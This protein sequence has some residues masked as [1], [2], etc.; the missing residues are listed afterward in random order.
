MAKNY[1][2]GF[3][4]VGQCGHIAIYERDGERNSPIDCPFCEN[5]ALKLRVEALEKK[6]RIVR[7]FVTLV[8]DVEET[9]CD[10]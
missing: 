4:H 3:V 7:S 5:E 10:I 8:H 9:E 6:L 1:T 2:V